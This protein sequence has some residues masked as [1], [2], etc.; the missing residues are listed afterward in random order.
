MI[1]A[2]RMGH[3]DRV[4]ERT[5]DVEGR[6]GTE[7]ISV[8]EAGEGGRPLLMVHG[9]TGA[10]EDFADHA[11]ALAERGWWVVA[12]DLRG[13]GAS[14]M[15]TDEADYS[16]TNYA[17]DLGDL[18]D[19][20][21]WDDLVLL[22]HSMGGMVAQVAAL[23]RPDRLRGLVLMDTSHDSVEV[24]D[25]DVA[26]MGAEIARTEGMAA[27]K[28]TLDALAEE[29]PLGSAA[30]ERMLRDRPGYRE[31]GDRKLLGSAPAMYS[32]MLVSLLDQE[33]RLEAL[34][35]LDVACLVIVGDQD[36]PFLATSRR[37]AEAIGG[38]ELAVIADAGHSP[39][40]ENPDAWFGA[41]TGFLDRLP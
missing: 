17:A 16:L 10:K 36:Q 8:I 40:F 23:T 2:D 1:L 15:P 13:H 12:P 38:A 31:F 24:I 4:Q 6:N 11:D 21:G 28:A 26:L 34:R 22:G 37:M 39:Q 33:D 7:P 20:L 30:Y 27:I 9:F 25:P 19:E 29:A 3:H 5:I 14:P 32:K 35:T 41:L 18:V